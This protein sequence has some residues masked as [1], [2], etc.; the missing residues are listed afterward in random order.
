MPGGYGYSLGFVTDKLKELADDAGFVLGKCIYNTALQ[1]KIVDEIVESLLGGPAPGHPG[2]LHEF[3]KF[4]K[5]GAF[6]KNESF[7]E[8]REWRLVSFAP[9]E[10][11]VPKFRKGKSMIIPF[12]SFDLARAHTFL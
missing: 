7:K 8:E 6:F 2:N 1:V 10:P 9:I 12:T 11:N 5:Y 3:A 4:L